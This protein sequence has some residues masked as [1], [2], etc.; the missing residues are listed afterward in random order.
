MEAVTHNVVKSRWAAVS[1]LGRRAVARPTRYRCGAPSRR[2]RA[3]RAPPSY[4]TAERVRCSRPAR[5]AGRPRARRG[6]AGGAARPLAALTLAWRRTPIRPRSCSPR[7]APASRTSASSS[8]TAT[9]PRSPRSAACTRSRPRGPRRFA[10]VA[11]ALAR[12]RVAGASADAPDGPPGAGPS[13]SAASPSPPRAAPRRT[14]P[15]SRRL[16]AR[17]RGRPGPPRRRRAAHGR[18]A[19][20]ARRHRRTSCWR[21]RRRPAAPSSSSGRCRCSTPIPPSRA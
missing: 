6:G 9:A 2:V 21:A 15:A 7:A 18:R 17:A 19:R 20:H 12:A 5:P 1:R 13:P 4:R 8:P 11:E 16:A 3:A 10:E 14:G